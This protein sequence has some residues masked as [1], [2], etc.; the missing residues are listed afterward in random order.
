M[1]FWDT[2]NPERPTGIKDP[3]AVLD[4]PID[5]SAWLASAGAVYASHAV[6]TSDGLT[7]VSHEYSSGVITPVISG[8]ALG[9]TESFT[10]RIQATDGRCDDRTFFLVS[11]ER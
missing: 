9:E 4:Y 5:F 3:G 11:Q 8:G 1:R 6:T 2:T 10:L 7:C